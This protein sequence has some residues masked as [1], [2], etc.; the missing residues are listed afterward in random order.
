ML[1][2][3]VNRGTFSSNYHVFQISGTT[4]PSI[5]EVYFT[6]QSSKVYTVNGCRIIIF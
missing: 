6:I 4:D 2:G 3:T 5:C 1:N